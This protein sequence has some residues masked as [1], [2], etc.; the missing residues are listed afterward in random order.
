MKK[1]ILVLAAVALIGFYAVPSWA[2][3]AEETARQWVDRAMQDS[4]IS[5]EINPEVNMLYYV[6]LM[7]NSAGWASFLVV[8]NWSL[9][10]RIEVYTS[11][12]PT[13][14]TPSDIRDRLNYVDPNA[15]AYLNAVN[16]GFASYGFTNWFGIVFGN[17]PSYVTCGVLL[18]S[19][20]FGLTWIPADGPYS[21]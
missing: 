3:P 6:D 8:T 2:G 10:T 16:L 14:G 15:V 9:N 5:A 20:E 13:S 17:W 4:E 11:F 19:S 1:A 12:V 21:F 7:S 18:Y